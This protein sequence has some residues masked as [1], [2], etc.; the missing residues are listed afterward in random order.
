MNLH[1]IKCYVK[2]ITKINLNKSEKNVINNRH[3]NSYRI[4]FPKKYK[5]LFIRKKIYLRHPATSVNSKKKEKKNLQILIRKN[6]PSPP[7]NLSKFKEKRKKIFTNINKKNL[8]SP[9]GNL[10]K[11]KKKEKKFKLIF[12]F[13]E[14]I[15]HKK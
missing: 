11:F 1:N 4:Y 10:G 13:S 12:R 3:R 7:G 6:L 9:P 14:L 5:I 15:I 8:P 2:T